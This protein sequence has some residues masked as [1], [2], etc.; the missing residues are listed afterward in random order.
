[1]LLLLGVS[2]GLTPDTDGGLFLATGHVRVL[3]D[4]RTEVGSAEPIFWRVCEERLFLIVF[5]EARLVEIVRL[6]DPLPL[7]LEMLIVCL[8]GKIASVGCLDQHFFGV[9]LRTQL[10]FL[11]GLGNVARLLNG[12]RS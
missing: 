10:D 7:C 8:N 4:L 9:V 1:M 5:E 6:V 11:R 2:S 3:R 12:G